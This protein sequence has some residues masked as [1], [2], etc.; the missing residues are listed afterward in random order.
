MLK[1]V[2]LLLAILGL[3]L[4]Y[5][6]LIPFLFEHGFDIPLLLQQL[7]VNRIST[8]FGLDVIVSAVVVIILAVS[9]KKTLKRYWYLPIIGTLTVGVSFGL[10]LLLYMREKGS[11]S[12]TIKRD[13]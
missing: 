13:E 5:S 10:P 7:F 8:F 1:T 3:I 2:Y 9:E 6:Q 12:F 4:P 11:N